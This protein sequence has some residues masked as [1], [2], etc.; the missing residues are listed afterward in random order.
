MKTTN[1][2]NWGSY[3]VGIAQ[4]LLDRFNSRSVSWNPGYSHRRTGPPQNGVIHAVLDA[5]IDSR[6]RMRRASSLHFAYLGK[7][8][9]RLSISL[10]ANLPSLAVWVLHGP[11]QRQLWDEVAHA[12]FHAYVRVFEGQQA[13]VDAVV[14]VL[15]CDPLAL[16]CGL[17][18]IYIFLGVQV[19]R[20]IRSL[21]PLAERK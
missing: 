4:P 7:K 15:L 9:C 3:E 14:Q 5:G 1:R 8:R 17:A 21:L 16:T 13:R 18:L 6:R 2:R 12:M 20:R 19:A 11:S 10:C